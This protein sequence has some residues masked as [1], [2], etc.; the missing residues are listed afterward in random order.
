MGRRYVLTALLLTIAGIGTAHADELP[1][2]TV[3]ALER[4]YH[5][6]RG[7][8]WHNNQGWLSPEVPPCDWYGVNCQRVAG[9]FGVSALDLY[10]NN[11][12]GALDQ[13]DI[14]DH[15]SRGLDLSDNQ[16][17]GTL[18]ELPWRLHY[19]DLSD[20]RL[21]GELPELPASVESNLQRLVLA[22]NHFVGEVPASWTGLWMW[23]LDLSDNELEGAIRPAL[24][25]ARDEVNL[26][27]NRYRGDIPSDVVV[28]HLT[29]HTEYSSAGGLNLCWN[30]LEI[31]S[32]LLEGFIAE[33][34][35]GGRDFHSC[36]N[37]ERL[38]L[39]TDL[40]GSWF[41]LERDGEGV[42]LQLLP[43]DGALLYHFG[44]DNAGRQH[45]LMS[46]SLGREL[47]HSL[48]WRWLASTRGQFG[49]GMPEGYLQVDGPRFLPS[50]RGTGRNWRMDR[51]SVDGLHIERIYHDCADC[52]DVITHPIILEV[53]SDRYDYQRLT[54]LAGTDCDNQH[55]NQKLSGAWYDPDRNGEG[56]V[57]EVLED[58]RGLV[59]WFTYQPDDSRH[60]AWM[61]GDGEF[62]GQTL[63]IDNL[64]QPTGGRWGENF[65][66]DGIV[67]KHWGSLI[68]E[69]FD[70]YTGHIH[71]ESTM[72]EYGSGDHPVERLSK[73]KLA[74]CD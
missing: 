64:L 17:S 13:S 2:E 27:G 4:F 3:E 63:V 74:E 14:F 5:Q 8:D 33:R 72:P 39:T 29:E 30:D 60:Q 50:G 61:M 67:K 53:H 59:Y 52:P 16:I 34:H 28:S 38:E 70:D 7:E 62:D 42:V 40:S 25:A 15:V 21:T 55:P 66:P 73:A 18:D 32:E 11:L 57:V 69:F 24:L 10:S 20:N 31:T 54:R 37:R 36:W 9:E 58:G 68:L 22:R 45:W 26:A 71:W 46:W 47:Q 65:D 12:V 1:T 56:F 19:V 35:V 41:D 6:L 48:H 51:T 43:D 44:F 49:E 23:H